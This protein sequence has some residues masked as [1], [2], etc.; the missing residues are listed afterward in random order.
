M[1]YFEVNTPYYA[2]IK[3]KNKEDAMNKYVE[4][5]AEDDGTLGE[6]MKEV[7]RDYAL[8]KFSRAYDENQKLLPISG[9]VEEFNCQSNEVIVVDG[10]LI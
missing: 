7:S 2:L 1:K 9:V 8:V 10:S 3:A 5:V 6:E 4:F